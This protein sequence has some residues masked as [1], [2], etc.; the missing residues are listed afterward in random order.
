MFSRRPVTMAWV[1]VDGLPE[2][3]PFGAKNPFNEVL[4]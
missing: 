2:K 4:A 3:P 1:S